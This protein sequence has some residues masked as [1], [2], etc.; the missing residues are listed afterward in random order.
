MSLVAGP[1][2][3]KAEG[4]G[5]SVQVHGYGSWAYKRTSNEGYIY[6]EGDEE[7]N[8][9]NVS[10]SLNVSARPTEDITAVIQAN[11]TL[12]Q[13]RTLDTNTFTFPLASPPCAA[14]PVPPP[15]LAN[16]CTVAVPQGTVT[17]SPES[18]IELDYAFAEWHYS[19]AFRLRA[20]QVKLPFGIYTEIYDVGTLRPFLD[21]PQGIYGA[22]A[23]VAESYQGGGITG[24]VY[25]DDWGLQYDVYGGQVISD[26]E[27]SP[28]NTVETVLLD[29]LGG[30]LHVT[31]PIEGLSFGTSG[32]FGLK[33]GD[34]F[35]FPPFVTHA[36]RGSVGAH[37][38]Y[39]GDNLLIR[40]EGVY[41][42]AQRFY[43]TA[44]AYL[45]VAY[46]FVDHVQLAGRL[47]Y[48]KGDISDN[49]V[50]AAALPK[51]IDRHVDYGVAL[52]YWF[53]THFVIK[54]AYHYIDGNR[55][56]QPEAIGAFVTF[57]TPYAGPPLDESNHLFEA[58]AQFSF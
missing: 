37:I 39:A 43:K 1:R 11:W 38:E 34:T 57:V 58:G 56:S 12:M 4:I 10:G 28:T 20:G 19:D 42:Y 31:T 50:L 51:S 35:T 49:P 44:A 45:E 13:G 7:G 2:A 32:Y 52:N 25:S 18:D 27:L 8:Y 9:T 46:M 24:N 17:K 5:D 3:A 14:I 41:T 33:S 26:L 16:G 48:Y 53:N 21:V 29:V 30:R 22:Q 55:Y 23:V 47:D 15:A 6:A 36:E 54:T 40:T